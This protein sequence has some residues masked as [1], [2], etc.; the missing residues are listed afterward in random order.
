MNDLILKKVSQT[1]K[2]YNMLTKGE[3]S[4]V[5]LSG[6]ADSVSLLLCLKMLGYDI[7]A[8]HINHQLRG[9]ESERDQRFCEQ[10]CAKSD[11]R[12][13]TYRVDVDEYCRENSVSVEQG[14]RELRY[15]IFEKINADRIC[16][17]HTLSDCIETSIFNFARGTGLKGLCS[18]PPKRGKIVRPLISCTRDEIIGFLNSIGQEYVTD[19]TNLTDEYTRNCIR[20]NVIPQIEKINPSLMKSYANTL[21]HL[22]KDMYFL[23]KTAKNAFA[24]CCKGGELDVNVLKRYDECIVD[25]VLMLWLNDRDVCVSQDKIMLMNDVLNLGGKLNIA[26]D[27]YVICKNGKAWMCEIKE[28]QQVDLKPV[29][30]TDDGRYC[31]AGKSIV[32]STVEMSD[33]D[34]E[35][36]N[37]HKKFANCCLDCD[38]IKGSLVLRRRA[39]GDTIRL[40]NRS[41]DYSIRKLLKKNFPAYERNNAILMYDDEG[42]VFVQGSGVCDRVKITDNTKR[43]LTFKI[44]DFI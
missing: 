41:E 12:L 16:T 23:E 18:I 17:A 10:L 35:I 14:A 21:E 31:F 44:D 29:T 33:I 7:L 19:S 30:I 39:E 34:C 37:V 22:R 5:C 25:R 42:A 40:V 8:C 27:R 36:E 26:Q 13:Y 3:R 15:G 2:K 11:V 43:L 20:H 24:V 38:K 6:G 4:L 28:H 1:I 9:E 32:V